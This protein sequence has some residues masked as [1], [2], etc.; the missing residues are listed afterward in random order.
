M[1]HYKQFSLAV[2]IIYQ[3]CNKSN[4]V[5][6]IVRQKVS[7]PKYIFKKITKNNKKIVRKVTDSCNP[8]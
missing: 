4:S 7:K 5:K 8:G 2:F 6:E 3:Y 1:I